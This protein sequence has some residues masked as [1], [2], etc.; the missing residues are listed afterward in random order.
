[1]LLWTP[2]PLPQPEVVNYAVG[3]DLLDSCEQA[4]LIATHGC[5]GDL[6]VRLDAN[7]SSSSSSSVRASASLLLGSYGVLL[8]RKEA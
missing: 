7:S 8:R 1:M 6:P 5:S 2:W 4:V 3:L